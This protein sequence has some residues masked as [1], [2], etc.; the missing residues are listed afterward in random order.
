MHFCIP[1]PKIS[2]DLDVAFVPGCNC[3][4]FGLTW[5]STIWSTLQ[6]YHK[7][8]HH[9]KAWSWK[10][11]WPLTTRREAWTTSSQVG[12]LLSMQ[13]VVE[14][15]LVSILKHP[16]Q[17]RNVILTLKISTQSCLGTVKTRFYF[18]E[19]L[20]LDT[21][22]GIRPDKHQHGAPPPLPIINM[23]PVTLL[24]VLLQV[25]HWT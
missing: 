19:M 13:P 22:L 5:F 6:G 10:Q 11:T 24:L 4:T 23:A 2:I 7:T 20:Q 21:V 14:C 9:H 1:Q 18:V 25:W 3:T 12:S 8:V 15:Q 17:L 16:F